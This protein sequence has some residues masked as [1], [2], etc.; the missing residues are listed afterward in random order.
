MK[1]LLKKHEAFETDIAV[2]QGRVKEMENVG[3]SLIQ[4]VINYGKNKQDQRNHSFLHPGKLSGWEDQSEN[5]AYEGQRHI[6][7]LSIDVVWYTYCTNSLTSA[8]KTSE[9]GESCSQAQSWP[10]GFCSLAEVPVGSRHSG[11]MDTWASFA[12]SYVVLILKFTV[13]YK[14]IE[15]LRLLNL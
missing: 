12:F 15:N 4:K 9:L 2:H 13:L 14:D 1:G 7:F 8:A 3:Q 5:Q 10:A 11:I 6:S